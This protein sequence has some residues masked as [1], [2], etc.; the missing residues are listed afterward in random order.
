MYSNMYLCKSTSLWEHTK[1]DLLSTT[2][3]TLQQERTALGYDGMTSD[4]T[5]Q[6]QTKGRAILSKG[7]YRGAPWWQRGAAVVLQ[8]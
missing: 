3:K 8:K 7:P 1:T 2:V 5:L 6:G 4:L